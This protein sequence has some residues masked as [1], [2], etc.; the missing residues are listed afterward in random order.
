MGVMLLTL[1]SLHHA[2]VLA[3]RVPG[4]TVRSPVRPWRSVALAVSDSP[5]QDILQLKAQLKELQP[6]LEAKQ[7]EGANYLQVLQKLSPD[8]DKNDAVLAETKPD[9]LAEIQELRSKAEELEASINLQETG[10]T[11]RLSAV[12]RMRAEEE[13]RSQL[14]AAGKNP[15]TGGAAGALSH[16]PP[17][18]CPVP[19]AVGLCDLQQPLPPPPG[20]QTLRRRRTSCTC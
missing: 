18:P 14:K 13:R 10:T 12:G 6:L 17:P 16:G 8:R 11:V 19:A 2:A 9:L 20:A 1:L 5:V 4:P 15:D 3:L 7:T